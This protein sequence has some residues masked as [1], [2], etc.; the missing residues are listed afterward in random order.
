M[1]YAVWA[2]MAGLSF[3]A[4]A[5]EAGMY[6]VI[7]AVMFV[8]SVVLAI[9]PYYAPLEVALL[10]SV[11]MAVQGLYMRSLTRDPAE[12]LGD[13]LGIHAETTVRTGDQPRPT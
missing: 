3:L 6:Y 12:K 5:T 8:V 13:R 4:H 2:A 7:A 10:M 9:T 11:N 1:A